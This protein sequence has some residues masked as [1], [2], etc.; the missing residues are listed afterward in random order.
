MPVLWQSLHWISLKIFD[1][2]TRQAGFLRA[3][4]TAVTGDH[5]RG[6]SPSGGTGSTSGRSSFGA[7]AG[8]FSTGY[9]FPG[10][11]A[12]GLLGFGGSRSGGRAG[13][14]AIPVNPTCRNTF[15]QRQAATAFLNARNTGRDRTDECDHSA[16]RAFGTESAT[17]S[18]R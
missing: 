10:S 12:G 15:R 5:M 3:A 11:S 2:A 14:F 1:D 8:G 7:G 4:M 9:G 18:S 16:L 13:S 6:L 17:A